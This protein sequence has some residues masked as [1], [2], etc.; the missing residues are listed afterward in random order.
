MNLRIK[1]THINV[2]FF[3]PTQK[4]QVPA[5]LILVRD[6]QRRGPPTSCWTLYQSLVDDKSFG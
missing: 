2:A 5:F 6:E 4:N 1:Q 3:K